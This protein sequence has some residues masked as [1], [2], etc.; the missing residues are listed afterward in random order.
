MSQDDKNTDEL[1]KKRIALVKDKLKG[2][3]AWIVYVILAALVV[4]AY[5]IRT[6][7][8]SKLRDITTG[9]WTL[10]PDLDPFLFL[11]WAKEILVNG[12]LPA[13]DPMRYVPLG[14]NTSEEMMLHSYMMVWFHNIV[15]TLGI[16]GSI[17]QSA[18]LYPAVLFALTVL[19]FF[20]LVRKIFSG[21]LGKNKSNIIA[22]VSSFLLILIPSL[23]PRTIAGI[24]EKESAGFLFLVLA[25]YF[26]IWA[27][28]SKS[29]SKIVI[30]SLLSAF[31]TAVMSL[32]WGGFIYITF[33]IALALMVAFLFEQIDHKRLLTSVLWLI[34]AYLIMGMFSPRYTIYNLISS[35]STVIPI[36]VVAIIIFDILIMKR[37]YHKFEKFNFTKKI[38]RQIFSLIIFIIL[39]VLLTILLFGPSFITDKLGDVKKSLIAP[40]TDRLGVTVAENRQPFFAE[41]AN[42]FGPVISGIPILFL[43]LMIGSI[44]LFYRIYSHL[45]RKDK[46]IATASY[47]YLLL[48]IVFSRYTSSGTFNG[49]NFISV[50]FYF[51]GFIVFAGVQAYTYFQIYKKG[52]LSK[53]SEIDFGS[54][55]LFA[56][57]FFSLVSARSAVRLVMVLGIPASI[58]SAYLVVEFISIALAQKDSTKKMIFWI[59]AGLFTIGLLMSAYSMYNETKGMSENYAPNAYTMQWQKAMQWVREN[60]P[61]NAVFGHWWDYGYWVQSIGERA[62]VLDGGN[63]IPYWNHLMGRYALTGYDDYSALEFLYTHNA[64]HFLIDMTDIGKYGA[65]SSIGSDAG[66]DRASWIPAFSRD[67][68]QIQEKKNSTLYVYSGGTALDADIIYNQNG[69]RI[70]LP[71]SKAGL[72]A[73]LVE[74]SNDGKIVSNPIAIFVYQN[75]QYRIP[76]RYAFD[77]EFHDFGANSGIEAGIFL[78]PR[79]VQNAQGQIGVEKNGAMLYLSNRTVKS[80]LARLYLY[81]EN[82][83]YFKLIHS[84]DDFLVAQMK[85]QSLLSADEDFVLY[86][87]LRG[88]LRIWSISYPSNIKSVP[89]Y[90]QTTDPDAK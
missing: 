79:A 13:I 76:V 34:P 90:L 87:E 70:F 59:L 26:F 19:A 24:P 20:F 10:G 62:T 88:P 46:I 1:V 17:E 29:W 2:G 8:L 86:S 83:S 64:T 27:W 52:E 32:I 67:N 15:S 65:F 66:Y 31:S 28:Q 57:F 9:G 30:L 37:M 43:L 54:I 82:D 51:S 60:T 22:L 50:I 14:F 81:K 45:S 36:I 16:S 23:L 5:W 38:S 40:V 12:F 71:A 18:A 49:T 6:L 21:N 89:A 58:L 69:T 63:A 44:Y 39:A 61:A 53:L 4:F 78:F 80:Q 3:Y 74:L 84:E 11:R 75:N 48:A 72:G 85:Q 56:F 35:T 77:G 42:Q 73:F 7:N 68:N 33:T 47:V 55:L 25:L 41:W